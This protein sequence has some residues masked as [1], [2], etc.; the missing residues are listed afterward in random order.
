MV[1]QSAY[2]LDAAPLV[3]A[4]R[5]ALGGAEGVWIVGGAVRDAALGRPVDDLDLAVAGDPGA[6]AKRVGAALGEHAF[7]LSAE[8]GTW[9]LVSRS[10]GW[11]IDLT[12][13]RGEAI[14][15]DLAERDFTIGAVAV[16]LAGG[17]PVDP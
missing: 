9:R 8:F 6:A 10:R 12:A 2:R 15:S 11:Q 4:V 14:E 17:E 3:A 5:D 13:L 16:P 1:D 7:E